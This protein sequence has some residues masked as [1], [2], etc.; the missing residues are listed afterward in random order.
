[1]KIYPITRDNGSAFTETLSL[2]F[3]RLFNYLSRPEFFELHVGDCSI[4]ERLPLDNTDL[5]PGFLYNFECPNGSVI[6]VIPIGYANMSWCNRVV[7]AVRADN[8]NVIMLSYD[9]CVHDI[10]SY[11]GTSYTTEVAL[12][13]SVM[14]ALRVFSLLNKSDRTPT[15]V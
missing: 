5:Y 13:R 14:Y 11:K 3:K 4:E 9:K 7:I 8:L 6:P 1:M 2:L 12:C 10:N 15:L